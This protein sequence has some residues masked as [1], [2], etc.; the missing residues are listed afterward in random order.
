MADHV[1]WKPTWIKQADG[2]GGW[3]LR[4]AQIQFLHYGDGKRPYDDH[5]SI[6]FIPFGVQQM[7]T[8]EIALIGAIDNKDSRG[9]PHNQKPVIAFSEDRGNTW[10]PLKMIDES[11]TCYGRTMVFTYLC[12]GELTFLTEAEPSVQYF[13]YDYGRTWPERQPLQPP[14]HDEISH[15]WYE[16]SS[17]VDRDAGY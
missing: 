13:S 6:H 3:L 7:D 1:G 14:T 17:L 15:L 10:T 2:N 11:D 16:G 8:G 9:W 5:K 4:P 12:K